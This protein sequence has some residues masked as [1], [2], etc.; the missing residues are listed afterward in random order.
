MVLPSKRETVARFGFQ[1]SKYDSVDLHHPRG[2][3][4][5]AWDFLRAIEPG[6]SWTVLSTRGQSRKLGVS[7][8]DIVLMDGVHGTLKLE[9]SYVLTTILVE[10]D[11]SM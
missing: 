9:V 6:L 2:E 1:I 10:L 7:D 11:E 8:S 4:F 5:R 3:S